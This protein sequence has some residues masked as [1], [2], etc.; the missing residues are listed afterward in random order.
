MQRDAHQEGCKMHL[1]LVQHGE[2]WSKEHDSERSLSEGGTEA[3]NDV[4]N[5]LEENCRI[6]VDTIHHSGKMRALETADILAKSVAAANGMK[7]SEGLAPMDDP[8]IWANKL[9]GMHQNVML[10]GH[11]SHL[12]KLAGLLLT[13]DAANEPVLFHNGGIVCLFRDADNR[14][15]IDWVVIPEILS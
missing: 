12:S 11:L 1:Y 13:G 2:A 10:V 8:S 5:F 15:M 14:W 4:N 6:E 7:E 3:V 9:K